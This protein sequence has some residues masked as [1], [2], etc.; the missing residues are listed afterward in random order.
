MHLDLLSA[1]P[2]PAL[3]HAIAFEVPLPGLC[4]LAELGRDPRGALYAVRWSP[5]STREPATLA[6]RVVDDPDG[7]VLTQLGEFVAR[8]QAAPLHGLAVPLDYGPTTTGKTYWTTELFECDLASV[9]A[10]LASAVPALLA[11]VTRVLAAL[12]GRGMVHGNLKA[13]NVLIMEHAASYR[14]ALTDPAPLRRRGVRADV[15]DDIR[16]WGALAARVLDLGTGALADLVTRAQDAGPAT[17]LSAQEL[18][19]ALDAMSAESYQA[20]P[21]TGL[22]VGSGPTRSESAHAR[23]AL[24]RAGFEVLA[25]LGQGAAASVFRARRDGREL[26]VKLFHGP[27]GGTRLDCIEAVRSCL[28][29]LD[30]DGLA[31]PLELGTLPTGEAYYTTRARSGSL[32]S[33]AHTLDCAQIL[34]AMGAVAQTLTVLH[35]AGIVHRDIKP[36]NL[37]A[38]D[39]QGRF[40]IADFDLAVAAEHA[41]PACSE[42][43]GAI[44]YRPPEAGAG[45]ATAAWDVWGWAATTMS[46]LTQR[47]YGDPALLTPAPDRARDD[48]RIIAHLAQGQSPI[49]PG[50]IELLLR[51]L[52]EDPAARPP[53]DEIAARMSNE[54]A[55]MRTRASRPM[56]VTAPEPDLL[57]PGLAAFTAAQ[58]DLFFGR[59]DDLARLCALLGHSR[60][61]VLLGPSGVGK[62]S[63]LQAGLMPHLDTA[64]E[65][66]ETPARV[67]H[68]RPGS[69]PF[70]ALAAALL[71][72]TS[73]GGARLRAGD[74]TRLAKALRKRGTAALLAQLAGPGRPILVID[75]CEE[76]F[77]AVRDPGTRLAFMAL[78]SAAVDATGDDPALPPLSIV[79]AVRDDCYGALLTLPVLSGREPHRHHCLAPLDEAALKTALEAPAARWGYHWEGGLSAA[80]AAQLARSGSSMSLLQLTAAELWA[81]RDRHGRAIPRAAL[82]ALGT[83]TDAVERHV[84]RL[85]DRLVGD[86]ELWAELDI[87][88]DQRRTQLEQ[89]LRALLLGLVDPDD[90][91]QRPREVAELVALVPDDP[92]LR[93]LTKRLLPRLV[94][95]GLLACQRVAVDPHG[96]LAAN[97]PLALVHESL[98]RDWPTLR[99]WLEEEGPR[100]RLI[101]ELR[102][103]SEAWEATGRARRALWTERQCARMRVRLDDLHLT[104]SGAEA[105]FWHASAREARR[106]RLRRQVTLAAVA[107]LGLAAVIQGALT[108]AG[109]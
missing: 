19:A 14:V 65:H 80:I 18:T 50:V 15:H 109:G 44:E 78:L 11:E 100:R 43:L 41:P 2:Q 90:R 6:L 107:V 106:L 16:A 35:Q 42:L 105:E 56:P 62:T 84:A 102:A 10:A 101:D 71:S 76:L 96:A 51:C 53:A 23:R 93:A 103:G 74:I 29:G 55:R 22:A 49:P 95:G 38:G 63:L 58:A 104:P 54:I 25:C 75:Q 20:V 72:S 64:G 24:E 60:L 61:V 108:L 91:V 82:V 36:S 13:E 40:A 30:R 59:E 87:A 99:R 8:M 52:A 77:T 97:E 45:A 1:R 48:A 33:L 69:R 46:A 85:F 37:L 98:I 4:V 27:S 34:D 79:M 83:S 21:H 57:Y 26:A 9:P 86:P 67:I 68:L 12:H 17:P 5:R 47:L 73:A 88:A 94:R 81:R 7:R 89:L 28:R 70:E 66:G 39:G 92:R 3:T 32:R 31:L